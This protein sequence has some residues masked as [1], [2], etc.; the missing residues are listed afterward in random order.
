VST[1]F[2]LFFREKFKKIS[3]FIKKQGKR[4]E[5]LSIYRIGSGLFSAG[6]SDRGGEPVSLSTADGREIL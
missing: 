3:L 6:I 1:G 2:L 4:E 5:T